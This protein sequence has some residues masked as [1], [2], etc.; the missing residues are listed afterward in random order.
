[1]ARYLFGSIHAKIVEGKEVDLINLFHP[2]KSSYNKAK[3]RIVHPLVENR[4]PA[5]HPC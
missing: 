4:L 3:P 5:G 2:L 1:M